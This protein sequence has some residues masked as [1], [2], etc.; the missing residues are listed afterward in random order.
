MST[1]IINNTDA[2]KVRIPAGIR[3]QI[4]ANPYSY[5]TFLRLDW[6]TGDVDVVLT[7]NS[8][9][10]TIT[11]RQWQ[12]FETRIHLSEHLTNREIRQIV[13]DLTPEIRT[14]RAGWVDCGVNHY[15]PCNGWT[16]DARD[17]V[18]IIR[19]AIEDRNAEADIR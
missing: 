5:V 1:T 9:R 14:A 12:G 7:D 13:A 6:Q 16:Q 2:I 4:T 15:R 18:S 10:W 3:A 8:E 11:D 19:Y 17:A